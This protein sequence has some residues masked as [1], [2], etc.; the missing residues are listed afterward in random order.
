MFVPLPHTLPHSLK[1]GLTTPDGLKSPPR[2]PKITMTTLPLNAHTL[3][4]IP[5]APRRRRPLSFSCLPP[6]LL[7]L[8]VLCV[9]LCVWTQLERLCTLVSGMEAGVGRTEEEEVW[10]SHQQNRRRKRSGRAEEGGG[11]GGVWGFERQLRGQ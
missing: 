9:R 10:S 3:N 2:A 6:S 5:L 11:W 4:P 7:L 1:S 8:R